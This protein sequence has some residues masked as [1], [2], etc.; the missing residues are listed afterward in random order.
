MSDDT[1]DSLLDLRGGWLSAWGL[2]GSWDA[3]LEPH[4]FLWL[5]L[6][7]LGTSSLAQPPRR[8]Q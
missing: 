5:V 4:S 7:D 6:G 3:L 8:R 2:V 1:A